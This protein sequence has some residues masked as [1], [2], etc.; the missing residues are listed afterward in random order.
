MSEFFLELFSEEIPP[1]LQISARENLLNNFISFFEQKK[2]NYH[3]NFSALST[4]NRL[5]IYFQNI[6]SEVIENSK[7]I[8]GPNI[9]VSDEALKGFLSSNKITKDKIFKKETDKGVF[10]FYKVLKKKI[11]TK[12]LLEENIPDMLTKIRWKKSMKWGSYDLYWGRPLK[13]IMGLFDGNTLKFNYHHL[14]SSNKTFIDKN[15]EEKTKIFKDFK[16]YKKFFYD[17]QIIIDHNERKKYIEKNLLKITKLKNFKIFIKDKLM[18]DVTNILDRPKILTCSFDKRFLNMPKELIIS[19]VEFHQKFFLAYDKN[20]E[21]INTFYVVADSED[22]NR[23]IKRGNENVVEARLTDAEYFW[24]KNK[25]KNMIKQVSSLDNINYFK[26]LGSYLDKVQRLKKIS[27]LLSD[28]FLIS[29]EKVEL[30][31]T[32]SKVDLLSELVNEFPELQGV[33]GGYFAEAQGFD[34]EISD[35]IKEQYLPSGPLGGIPRNNYSIALSISDKIDTLVG[36]FG[37]NIMPSSS[38]DPYGLR[39]LAI[40]LIRIIVHNKKNIKLKELINFSC[41]AYS[42]QSIKFN[43]KTITDKLSNFIL[44][45]FKYFMKEKEIRK[46]IIESSLINFKIDDLLII[47]LKAQKLN[48]IINKEIGADLIKNYKRSFNILNSEMNKIDNENFSNVDPALFKSDYEKDLYKKLHEIIKDF[49][50][51]KIENDYDTQLSLLSTVKQEVTNFFENVIVNDSDESIKKNRLLLLKLVC[52][53][54]D[55]Y[56]SFAKLETIK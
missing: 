21:L 55:N 17:Q 6:Q 20:S 45:R 56:L 47:Y 2:I 38:K 4:P 7:E 46:D 49:S 29:K 43:N 26:G 54:F 1:N 9:N 16:S 30:A 42:A 51:I 27:G 22:K 14:I 23:L 53:T 15:F 5:I 50:N 11:K 35:S 39:R 37:L 12:N 52:K 40:G 34:K 44:E 41:Q 32:L 48:K 33:L 19:T 36:F 10:Y 18:N 8:R 28:E 13:S 25:S 24:E 3:K 31:S